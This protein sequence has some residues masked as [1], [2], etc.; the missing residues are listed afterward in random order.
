MKKRIL[1]LAFLV[2]L[3]GVVFALAS[4]GEPYQQKF[5][6]YTQGYSIDGVEVPSKY[7]FT[8]TL[9]DIINGDEKPPYPECP[10]GKKLKSYY[11]SVYYYV[12]TFWGLEQRHTT[13]EL[14]D[15]NLN[16]APVEK[17][18]RIWELKEAKDS[19]YVTLCAE[20]KVAPYSL[21]FN[22]GEGK[23]KNGDTSV[24]LYVYEGHYFAL[25]STPVL[26]GYTFD[27]WCNAAGVK[28]PKNISPLDN[29]L[30]KGKYYNL[31]SSVLNFEACYLPNAYTLT[32]DYG[33]EGVENP[34]V[35]VHYD[36]DFPDL[37]AYYKDLGTKEILGWTS[38]KDTELPL[39]DRISGD[40][41]VYPIWKD[42]K[43]VDFMLPDG[44]AETVKVSSAVTEATEFPKP[45]FPGY[46]FVSW[47]DAD[48][49]PI[50]SAFYAD[51][52]ETYYGSWEEADYAVNFIC[53]DGVEVE[54]MRHTY[55]IATQLPLPTLAGYNFLG[56][57]RDDPENCSYFLP[58]DLW[59]DVTLTAKFEPRTF[60]FS[61]VADGVALTERFGI[62]V[63]G[64]RFKIAVPEK[65]GYRF[66]GWFDAPEGG[67]QMTD[68]EGNSLAPWTSLDEYKIFYAVWEELPAEEGEEEPEE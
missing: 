37:S 16:P 13:I 2:L 6:F 61:L 67:K 47:L 55:G 14:F 29:F 51:L 49:N 57:Y 45:T 23:F 40:V 4:C 43:T 22:T 65:E 3:F 62:A 42:Y 46:K 48:G 18:L 56:W 10:P 19:C 33:I 12:S 50:E 9:N 28:I 64:E 31:S 63:Y 1:I 17:F 5:E 68:V 58:A 30:K 26:H 15:E 36:E 44:T 52:Q 11:A 25:P 20:F 7:L 60:S 59:E 54:P 66:L 32:V 34:T 35:A 21:V 53:P 39:P 38:V 24:C 8:A 41:T 27:G